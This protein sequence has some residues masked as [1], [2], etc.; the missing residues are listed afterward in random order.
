MKVLTRYCEC[1]SVLNAGRYGHAEGCPRNL[2]RAWFR[3]RKVRIKVIDD[4]RWEVSRLVFSGIAFYAG[5]LLSAP[6][7][8]D[9]AGWY[10]GAILMTAGL[11]GLWTCCD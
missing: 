10:W 5:L 1:G 3:I 2:E 11:V 6:A 8:F 4:R 7:D 9:T